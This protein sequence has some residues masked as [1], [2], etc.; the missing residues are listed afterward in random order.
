M[1]YTRMRQY[2]PM[3]ED[4]IIDDRNELTNTEILRIDWPNDLPK[5]RVGL[6]QDKG[7]YP[8]WTRYARFLENNSIPFDFYRIHAHDWL[9]KSNDFDVIIGKPT[10]ATYE[11][12]E[13]IEKVFILETHLNKICFPDLKDTILYENKKVESY[14]AT[15]YR[16]P[17]IHANISNDKDDALRLIEEMDFPCVS[18]IVPGSGSIGVELVQSKTQAKKI[19]NSAFS[20]NGRKTYV[21]YSR[22][23]NYIY[24]QDFIQNDGYDLRVIVVGRKVFGF[25]RKALKGDFRAS[26]MKLEEKR[27][28]PIE[29]MKIA[30][31]LS[32]VI[33][34][35]FLVVDMLH[36][37][38]GKYYINEISPFC[39]I[40]TQDELQVNGVS[41]AYVFDTEEEYHFEPINY[42]LHEA[43][44]LEFFE[45]HYLPL[46]RQR[47]S[48]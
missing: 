48:L 43:I 26:G 10:S 16:F 44:L 40:S 33:N 11:L 8:Y 23:K 15:I 13:F 17:F 2:F 47:N 5:P 25:Y 37:K 36:G 12:E 20:L 9:E 31:K 35:P 39:G 3:P 41:G 6:I 46:V 24:F 1:F 32:H 28:L 34:S 27:E 42:W 45:N 14:L 38:D 18:K 4:Q 22:Q 30:R 29:A 21:V 19:I 7:P